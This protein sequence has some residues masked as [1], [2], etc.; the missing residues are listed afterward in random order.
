MSGNIV[1]EQ[2]GAL[3]SSDERQSAPRPEVRTSFAS[4]LVAIAGGQFGC[5]A[6]AGLTELCFARLLGP[7][8]QG[9][10]SLC[11]MSVV[12]GAVVGSI[13][14]EATAVVWIS[15]AKGHPET[16]F[17]AVML[18]VASG[19]AIACTLWA[20]IY[21]RWHPKFLKG[22]TPGL[23][24]LVLLAIPATVLFSMVTALFAGEERFRLRSL[25]ALINRVSYLAIFLLC[26][27][28][29]GRRPEAGVLGYLG[30][31]VVASFIGWTYLRHFFREIWKIG[32]A[33]ESLLPT[34]SFG[35]RGQSGTL[36]T[37]FSYRLDVFMVNYFLDASQVG[38][39][40]L[41]VLISETLW[42]LPGIVST[43]LCPRTART[44]DSGADSFTS[45]VLRQVFLMT[46]VVGLAIAVFS[47]FV[48]PLIFGARFAPSVAV[49]WWILPGTIMLAL[50]KVC[51]AD[52]VG[53]GLVIHTPISSYIGMVLTLIL[54]WFL[55]PSMG[56]RGAALAS[57]IAYFAAGGYLLFM[58]KREV[59]TSWK[60]LL[61]PTLTELLAY[62][63]F[64]L[65][66]RER[67][68]SRQTSP[69]LNGSD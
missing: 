44:V 16:W 46:M 33:R 54:D 55:I 32:K 9:L 13:G 34:L 67:F 36:A 47:P 11:L 66:L 59:K 68:G 23:A 27:P 43:A 63:R 24:W 37:F 35:V 49:I 41:G 25:V 30:G 5:V 48:L 2:V 50:G 38:L 53:R 12:F 51:G 52:L 56:I 18:W 1:E 64:W 40:S 15:K 26:I 39:Y 65:Q 8:P 10:I 6:I 45:M 57:S 60:T 69:I 31:L 21:W 14:S 42:Q 58:V 7:A 20:V 4:N 19:T 28:L 62:K 29:L 3:P 17:S 22:L 61:L